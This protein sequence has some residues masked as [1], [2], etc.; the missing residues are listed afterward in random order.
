MN[1]LNID[2]MAIVISIIRC[3]GVKKYFIRTFDGTFIRYWLLVACETNKTWITVWW[4]IGVFHA[5]HV[6]TEYV[7]MEQ[8]KN[9]IGE[10]LFQ[11]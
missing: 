2:T 3:I 8:M 10:S 9:A 6:L 11:H 5:L 1:I 4:Y 7:N